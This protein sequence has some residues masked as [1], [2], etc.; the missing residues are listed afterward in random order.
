A[1]CSLYYISKKIQDNWNSS[2]KIHSMRS[3]NDMKENS[4]LMLLY[5]I[6]QKKTPVDATYDISIKNNP[7]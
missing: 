3:I 5:E 1:S 6:Y 7:L 2:T 4:P